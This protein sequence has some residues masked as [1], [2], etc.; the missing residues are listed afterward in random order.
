MV[1][2]I[3]VVQVVHYPL[4]G[5]VGGSTFVDY[6]AGHTRRMGALLAAPALVEVTT[7]ALVVFQ[8]PGDVSPTTALV[9][10]GLLALV[11][12]MTAAVQVGHHRALA[13]GFD[14]GVHRRLVH[15]N[16]WRTALWSGRGVLAAVMLP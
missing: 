8:L 5:L 10:A 13:A 2:L 15:G 16:W 4:F 11:W 9:A 1:G 12:V 6:E 14:E 7:A 3:W